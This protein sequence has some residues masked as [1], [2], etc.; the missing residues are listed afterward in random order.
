MVIDLVLGN[1]RP[2]TWADTAA[3]NTNIKS[4]AA[5]ATKDL[6]NTPFIIPLF[7]RYLTDS[8]KLLGNVGFDDIVRNTVLVFIYSK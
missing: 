6:P 3:V 2:R 1:G 7:A 5:T 8:S 4:I